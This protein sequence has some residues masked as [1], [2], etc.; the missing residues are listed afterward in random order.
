M[1]AGV[2]GWVAV[3]EDGEGRDPVDGSL[4]GCNLREPFSA[5]VMVQSDAQ[6]VEGLVVVQ[7][8]LALTNVSSHSPSFGANG[9]TALPGVAFLCIVMALKGFFRWSLTLLLLH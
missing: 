5:Q 7:D 8:T 9:S 1:R 4:Q 3:Q 2:P 6:S